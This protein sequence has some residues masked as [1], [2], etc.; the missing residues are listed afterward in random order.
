MP[1][2][3]E[4]NEVL[5][6]FSVKQKAQEAGVI[7]N[8]PSNSNQLDA[9]EFSIVAHFLKAL[10]EIR[11]SILE[12]QNKLALE[13]TQLSNEINVENDQHE[14]QKLT[15]QIEP[16]V[17]HLELEYKDKLYKAKE[18]EE[19]SMRYL[20]FFEARNELYGKPAKYPQSLIH[21]FAII[22]IIAFLEWISLSAFY[23]EGSDFGIIGGIIIAAVFSLLNL[24]IAILLGNLSRY[25]NHRITSK[26]IMGGIA[27]LALLCSFSFTTS[28]A[29][30]YRN[31]TIENIQI[32]K[33]KTISENKEISN[34][35]IYRSTTEESWQAA[36]IAWDKFRETP[37]GFNNVLT[38]IMVVAAYM[39]GIFAA[40]KGYKM[41]D[42]YPGY[43]PLDRDLKREQAKYDDIKNRFREQIV[44]HLNDTRSKQ[45]QLLD[46]ATRNI[47]RFNQMLTDS[48]NLR[49]DFI[50]KVDLIRQNCNI[51]VKIYREENKFVRTSPPPDYFAKEVDLDSSLTNPIN[52]ASESEKRLSEEYK[53]HLDEFNRIST[54]NRSILQKKHTEALSKYQE[55]INSLER[56]V[57]EKLD[58]EA[59]ATS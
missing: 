55:L 30:H 26:K 47:R 10:R 46:N 57:K 27:S 40:Y 11:Q 25:F 24:S 15:D 8:P 29:A 14:Y 6:F 43:G 35:T 45:S 20:R 4:V 56:D 39:F 23:A 9:T 59:R 13:R 32:Q 34:V 51:V 12:K 28:I 18:S 31:A 33:E 53:D 36:K 44:R 7:N 50:A 48:E 16:H 19:R 2:S 38:W 21:H 54:E 3:Y 42:P 17:Q 37:F 52:G 49:N 1:T 22:A 5:S 58:R 41:D